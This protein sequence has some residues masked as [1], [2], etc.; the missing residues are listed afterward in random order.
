MIN[1]VKPQR[2]TSSGTAGTPGWNFQIS[3]QPDYAFVMVDIPAGQTL[4]VE[5][6]AMATMDTHLVMKTKLR[7]G[8]GRL[9][10]GESIF[11]NEFTAQGGPGQ[12]GI[13]PGAPGDLRHV[14]L[15]DQTIYLQNSAYVAC[16]G[17]VNIESK[18]QG[19][20]KGFF[21]GESLFLIRASGRGDLWFSS[22]GGIIE[23]DVDGQYVVDTGNI[24]A[25]T[26]GLSYEVSRIGGYKSLFFSGEG[27]VCRFKGTG[28][29]WVQTRKVGALASWVWPFRPARG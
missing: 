2:G 29:I 26:D 21:S 8:L 17:G 14:F 24:V 25:F 18:W 7:G 9:V 23:M 1:M 28:R 15:N 22:Y 16:T 10:T 12:I 3:G 6:S 27:F 19:L 11:I 13:A 5:A 20:L 4:K